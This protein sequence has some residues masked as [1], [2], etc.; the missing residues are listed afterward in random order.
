M[1]TLLIIDDETVLRETLSELFTMVGHKVVEAADGLDGLEKVKVSKPDLIICDIMMPKLD[2]Y[3]FVEQLKKN[4]L[5]KYS[6]VIF[7]CKNR[8]SR[9]TKGYFIRC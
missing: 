8:I 3:G 9:P 5:H 7:N 1:A 6:R 2:G 4:R